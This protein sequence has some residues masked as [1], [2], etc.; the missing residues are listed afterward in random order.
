MLLQ[1]VVLQRGKRTYIANTALCTG[2]VFAGIAM[3]AQR[4]KRSP[5]GM[6]R[7]PKRTL[8]S[9]KIL[10]ELTA[11]TPF[12]I[13]ELMVLEGKF[14]RLGH[15]DDQVRHRAVCAGRSHSNIPSPPIAGQFVSEP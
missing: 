9:P 11:D 6:A 10:D 3:L 2:S 15:R 13:T 5:W 4:S 1:A 8:V 12:G 14:A 7:M